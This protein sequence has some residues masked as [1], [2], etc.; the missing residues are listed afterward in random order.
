MT[1][2][3]YPD[4]GTLMYYGAG[5]YSVTG[6]K[7]QGTLTTITV[8]CNI[9]PNKGSYLTG[10]SG[11]SVKYRYDVFCPKIT[12]VFAETTGLKFGFNGSTHQVLQIHNYSKTTEFQI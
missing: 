11:D 8:A 4:T 1:Y 2:K 7:T 6:Y 3:R 9:Q 10:L 5:T 12:T